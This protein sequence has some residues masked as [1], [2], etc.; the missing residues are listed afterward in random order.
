MT[1][2]HYGP[3][4]NDKKIG[5]TGTSSLVKKSYSCRGQ[6]L[7]EFALVAIPFFFL[8]F[9]VIDF[10]WALFNQM[11]VQDAVREAGRY[12]ATGNHITGANGSTV[13]RVGSIVQVLDSYAIGNG[14]SIQQISISSVYG[15]SV[16]YNEGSGS[17]SGTG[18]AGGPGDTVT[19]TATCAAPMLTTFIGKFFSSDSRYHFTAS[20][21][22]RNEPILP[23]QTN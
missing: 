8:I 2:C 9:S 21:T 13:S 12:A 6:S 17:F 7:I 23:S 10:S 22:F 3:S 1:N 16:T 11:N 15:G 5:K 4:S 20:S 14:V 19:I 18:N